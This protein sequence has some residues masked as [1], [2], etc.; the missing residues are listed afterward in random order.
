MDQQGNCIVK[1]SKAGKNLFARIPD[2]HRNAIG[3]GDKVKI[4]VIEKSLLKDEVK[5]KKE[6]KEF[7]KKPNGEKLKG[8]IL[9]Y[10]VEIPIAKIIRNMPVS[11]AEKLLYEALIK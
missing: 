7:L 6:L 10:P 2:E 9:G 1:V 3:R 11:K 8:T 5:I 4:V